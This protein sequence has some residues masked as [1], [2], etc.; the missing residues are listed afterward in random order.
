MPRPAGRAGVG[1]APLLSALAVLLAAVAAGMVAC[2]REGELAPPAFQR[3]LEAGAAGVVSGAAPPADSRDAAEWARLGSPPPGG[4]ATRVLMAGVDA[5]S[6]D[7][8]VALVASPGT[9]YR[10]R[11]EVPDGAV[12]RVGLGYPRPKPGQPS[13]RLHY[14]IAARAHEGD[15]AAAA[16]GERTLLFE[17]A[18]AS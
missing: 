8:R 10:Y 11:V 12:L 1:R 14:R 17:W 7:S 5:R 13:H 16:A 18:G 9:V 15:G 3:L 6:Y 2:S 4:E